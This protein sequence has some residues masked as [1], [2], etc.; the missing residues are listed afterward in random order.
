MK[1][2]Q[3]YYFKLYLNKMA[4]IFE[5]QFFCKIHSLKGQ[6]YKYAEVFKLGTLRA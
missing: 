2:D 5:D 4:E 3:K 6:N 1:F